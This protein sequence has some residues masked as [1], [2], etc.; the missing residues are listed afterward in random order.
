[1]NKKKCEVDTAHSA[2]HGEHETGARAELYTHLFFSASSIVP[3]T[4]V[5]P[6]VDS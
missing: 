4:L 6:L 3:K 2:A 5:I 1:M